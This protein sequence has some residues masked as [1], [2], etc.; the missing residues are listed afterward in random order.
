MKTWYRSKLLWVGIIT[1]V[2]GVL[3][4][5]GLTG[6]FV[7]DDGTLATILGLIVTIL[8]FFTKDPLL[9]LDNKK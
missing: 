6:G 9:E 4:K 3:Q 1:L 5:A 7:L 8:R 2:Y